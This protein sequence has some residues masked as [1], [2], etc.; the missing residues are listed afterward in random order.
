MESNDSW[1]DQV[2]RKLWDVFGND[3]ESGSRVMFYLDQEQVRYGGDLPPALR[4]L[5]NS[6]SSDN[7]FRAYVK[8]LSDDTKSSE[9][10]P[11]FHR[12]MDDIWSNILNASDQQEELDEHQ[13]WDVAK[14]TDQNKIKTHFSVGFARAW[15][16]IPDSSRQQIMALIPRLINNRSMLNSVDEVVSLFSKGA[17]DVVMVG[18]AAVA[19]AYDVWLNIKRWWKGEISGV[20]CL[21][22]IIDSGV[23]IVS[24]VGGGLAGA[25]I[26]SFFGKS[27]RIN[28]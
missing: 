3:V 23:S 27:N 7:A 1:K 14:I 28:I 11:K 6:L 22:N 9:N 26:G 2:Y 12:F 17:G 8:R 13:C 24:G 16:L 5:K 18:L 15:S 4:T 25:S 20:R 10:N 21:K 19:L